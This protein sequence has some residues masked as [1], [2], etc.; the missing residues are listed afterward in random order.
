MESAKF[1]YLLLVS[2]PHADVSGLKNVNHVDN[3]GSAS[4]VNEM[5]EQTERHYESHGV[6][7]ESIQGVAGV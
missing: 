4:L 6:S 7:K 3:T 5:Q 1:N 2:P